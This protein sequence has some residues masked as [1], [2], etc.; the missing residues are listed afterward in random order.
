MCLG[1]QS[2]HSCANVSMSSESLPCKTSSTAGIIVF[3]ILYGF[4]S[5][6]VVFMSLACFA[7]VPRDPR[8]IGSHIPIGHALR[9]LWCLDYCHSN[10]WRVDV[11]LWEVL[12]GVRV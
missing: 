2:D 1:M 8:D 6:A 4:P 11:P 7:Q 12:V 5:G 9:C 3:P 10:Q